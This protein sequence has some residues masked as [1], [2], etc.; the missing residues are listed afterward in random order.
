MTTK[1]D[2][3]VL[4]LFVG[5]DREWVFWMPE[6]YYDTSAIGDRRY[7]KWHRNGPGADQPTDIFPADRFEA[8]LRRPEV[9]TTLIQTADLAQALAAVPPAARDP[10]AL[11]AQGAPPVVE[12]AGPAGLVPDEPLVVA[13]PAIRITPTVTADDGRS[14]IREVRVQ[15]DGQTVGAPQLFNPPR[16]PRSTLPIDVPVESGTHR[17]SVVAVN[18]EGRTRVARVRR[19]GDCAGPRIAP[20]FAVLAIGVPRS[21]P[22]GGRPADPLR[23]R[24]RDGSRRWL[25]HAG[26]RGLY[27][28]RRPGCRLSARREPG[29]DRRGHRRRV[30]EGQGG[31]ARSW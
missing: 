14:P 8:E 16:S 2:K 6:G 18:A 13:A 1:R 15:V 7:L 31:R 27:G 19:R 5:L 10:E 3:P 4:S 26:R 20:R 23:R 17:V 29:H 21:V 28:R 12:I 11:V 25:R 22:D 24:R 9:L 30:R